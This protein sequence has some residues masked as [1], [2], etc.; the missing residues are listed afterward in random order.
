M[1]ITP[2]DKGALFSR[3]PLRS[4]STPSRSGER[5]N[6]RLRVLFIKRIDRISRVSEGKTPRTDR[7]HRRQLGRARGWTWGGES[8]I[9]PI[10]A[11]R[12]RRRRCLFF[13]RRKSAYPVCGAKVRSRDSAWEGCSSTPNF[14]LKVTTSASRVF[15]NGKGGW[16]DRF[17]YGSFPFD[18]RCHELVSSHVFRMEVQI[19]LYIITPRQLRACGSFSVSCAC[20]RVLR[21][22]RKIRR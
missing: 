9:R 19:R 3:R 10:S 8:R 5:D 16:L 6:C 1:A 7:K 14:D 17:F 20:E 13:T 21:R 12:R 22:A 15:L 18:E 2:N 11:L 4:V